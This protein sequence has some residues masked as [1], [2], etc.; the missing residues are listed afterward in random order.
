[1]FS[2]MDFLTC[3]GIFLNSNMTSCH[4]NRLMSFGDIGN[5]CRL[6]SNNFYSLY[7]I[8]RAEISMTEKNTEKVKRSWSCNNTTLLIHQSW[9]SLTIF[10]KRIGSS[11]SWTKSWRQRNFKKRNLSGCLENRERETTNFF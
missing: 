2:F 9:V 6:K 3:S 10:K 4:W 5:R 8:K 1:M 11:L 7:S